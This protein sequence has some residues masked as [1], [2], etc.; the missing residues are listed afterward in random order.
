MVKKIYT[1][2]V[3]LS[4]ISGLL[5]VFIFRRNLS[6]EASMINYFGYLSK[7][8]IGGA[9]TVDSLREIF[10]IP[11]VGFLY[12]D[13]FDIVNVGLLSLLFI[14]LLHSCYKRSK[15]N[16]IIN[17]ILLLSCLI[18]YIVSNSAL[19]LFF[20]LNNPEKLHDL[21]TRISSEMILYD[22]SVLLLYSFGLFIT[23]SIRKY[24]LCSNFT[25][26]LGLLTN[27]IG[28]LYFPL[29]F[30]IG[31][32]RFLAIVLSA[33]FTVIWHTN[34]AIHNFRLFKRLYSVNKNLPDITI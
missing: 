33:P 24:Q 26:S 12:F 18:M 3:L 5:S 8:L 16:S 20:N 22:I 10:T 28:L 32:Y 6:A 14:P 13:F 23:L 25:V 2:V 15:I 31:E 27:I 21:I 9:L 17:S 34:I 30:I 19:P 29:W 1:F 7:D 4:F 11:L